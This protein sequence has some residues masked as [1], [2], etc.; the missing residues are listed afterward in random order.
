MATLSNKWLKV[1]FIFLLKT[2]KIVIKRFIHV[3]FSLII[4]DLSLKDYST[5]YAL[6][7]GAKMNNYFWGDQHTIVDLAL[8]QKILFIPEYLV[9]IMI[10]K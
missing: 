7:D 3:Q 1:I 2:F 5:I 9:W 4:W 8:E 6:T 10:I